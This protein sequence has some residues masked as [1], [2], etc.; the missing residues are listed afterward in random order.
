MKSVVGVCRVEVRRAH[1]YHAVDRNCTA[2][3][4]WDARA[5]IIQCVMDRKKL[6]HVFA[7]PKMG[8][9]RTTEV[10]FVAKI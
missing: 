2:T 3:L 4:I 7:S 8:Q 6:P 10:A 9:K 5:R 1:H